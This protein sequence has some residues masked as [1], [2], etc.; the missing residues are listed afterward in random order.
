MEVIRAA[1]LGYCMGVR[2]A[3]DA[4]AKALA[5]KRGTGCKVYTLGP[6]IHN[7]SVLA[8]LAAEGLSVL[9]EQTLDRADSQSVVLIRAHGTSPAVMERL[10]QAGCEV[11]DA[12]CPRVHLSQKR[13]QEWSEKGYE[14]IIAGDKNHGEVLS[15]SGF[16]AAPV[17]V[18]QNAEEAR[19]LVPAEKSVL[20]AQTTF[21][22]SVFAEISGI[23]LKKNSSLLVYNSICS[24]TL[25]RQEALQALHGR[26]DGIVV[27][28]GKNSANTKRLYETAQ[29]LFDSERG[30]AVLIED[31]TQLPSD[32]CALKAVGITA[33]ASTPEE[34]IA[35]VEKRLLNA[36]NA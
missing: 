22:P 8:K 33:G 11:V 7:P 2:R 34:V 32:F 12:T 26:V 30:R 16:A 9:S 3:V 5:E 15:I 28:G 21:S 4:A 19:N 25:E 35:A 18:V 36:Q 31:E 20:I 29:H 24:A 17:Q 1:V 13:A 14:I 6:L 23:L 27:V 10:R